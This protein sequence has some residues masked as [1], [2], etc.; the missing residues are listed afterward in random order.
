MSVDWLRKQSA[1]HI[2]A[3]IARHLSTAEAAY[4]ATLWTPKRRFEWLAG[5]LA[6]KC[7]V[8]AYLR[9]HLGIIKQTQEIVVEV[10]GEGPSAGKPFVDAGGEIGIS[11]SGEFAIGVCTTEPVGVDLERNR[12]LAP[13]LVHALGP[14]ARGV[15]AA[16]S[17]LHTMP[18]PLRWACTEAVLKHYGFGLRIDPREVVLT[19]WRTDGSFLWRA[20]PGL[21]REIAALPWPRHAWA[22]EIAGYA[23]ALVW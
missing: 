5:R 15:S 11:H 9:L 17:R 22:G 18:V 2:A 3:T 14:A 6:A 19:A 10:I 1:E 21:R 8:C 12:R 23:L 13:P 16:S 7:A 4:A 20:G